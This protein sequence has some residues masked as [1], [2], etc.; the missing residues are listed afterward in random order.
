MRE[1]STRAEVYGAGLLAHRARVCDWHG[2]HGPAEYWVGRFPTQSSGFNL[3]CE[4]HASEMAE[5]GDLVLFL[6]FNQ[7]V[8]F[9][10]PV[11]TAGVN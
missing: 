2:C 9:W 1:Q 5:D 8:M 10:V 7:K 4:T 6:G 11:T 3:G